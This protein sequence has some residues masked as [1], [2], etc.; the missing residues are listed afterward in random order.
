MRPYYEDDM[1]AIYNGDCRDI[2]PHVLP[3]NSCIVTDP[4]YGTGWVRGGGPK[5]GDFDAQMSGADWDKWD[6]SWLRLCSSEKVSCFAVFAPDSRIG[7]LQSLLG[8]T[9]LRY[10]VKSNPRPPLGGNDS[11]SVEPIVIY[12]RIRFSRGP[13]HLVAYNGDCIHHP[14]EKPLSVMSWIISGC[15]SVDETVV[16]P[17]MGGGSTLRA[18]KNLSRRCIGIELDES[19][20]EVAAKRM[21]Q[22]VLD[23]GARDIKEAGETAYNKPLTGSEVEQQDIFEGS[24]SSTQTA[25]EQ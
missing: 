5:A 15:A 12:P 24:T 23:L 9:R 22:C 14:C 7:D 25:K 20:C 1:V 18:A 16:D 11:P 21:A 8:R 3:P 10:Y 6:S 2:L 19:Y 17:F 4:P 13:A